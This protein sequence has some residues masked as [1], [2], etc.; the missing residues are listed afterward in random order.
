[1][2]TLHI[3][4]LTRVETQAVYLSGRHWDTIQGV[5]LGMDDVLLQTKEDWT[6][7]VQ[8]SKVVALLETRLIKQSH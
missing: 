7:S 4:A 3:P 6:Y 5:R 8:T 1:M 2:D